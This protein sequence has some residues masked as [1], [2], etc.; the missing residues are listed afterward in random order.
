MSGAL[1]AGPGSSGGGS[2]QS[3]SPVRILSIPKE[4]ERI[5]APSRRP[6]GTLRKAIRIRAGYV[7]QEEVA[8]YQS[9]GT[10]VSLSSWTLLFDSNW[11][12]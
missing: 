10:L 4:G 11:R 9:K 8:I 12:C 6:D 5:I 3:N 7:A 1:A 2:D